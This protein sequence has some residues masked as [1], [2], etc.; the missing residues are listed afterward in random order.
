M[1]VV[2]AGKG[3]RLWEAVIE[4][5][6]LDVSLTVITCSI[7]LLLAGS[8]NGREAMVSVG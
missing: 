6:R 8:T 7:W 4:L 1:P 2:R 5:G 3:G